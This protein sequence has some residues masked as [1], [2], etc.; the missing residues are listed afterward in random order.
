MWDFSLSKAIGA[1]IRTAPFVVLRMIVYFG[2]G[3]VYVMTVGIG[4]AVGYG[5]G[6]IGSNPDAPIGGAFWGGAIGFGLT[7][8]VLYFA[9]EYILYLVKA[10]HIAC[11]V[12]VLDDKPIPGGQGQLSYGAKFVETHFAEASVLFGVDQLIKAVLRSLFRIINF[13]TAFLP[14][15]G[16]Q[17]L[18]QAAEGVIRLSLTYVD[19]VL[20]AYLIRTRTTN[21]WDT[22]RDGLILYAQ[23]Y[24]HFL[25]NALW[26][27]MFL[28]LLTG[29]IFIVFL[30]PAAG[31]V[32][33]FPGNVTFWGFAIAFVF[34][35]AFKAAILDPI[36]VA[37]LMQV[38]F[39]TIEGQTTN[40]DW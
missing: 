1:V 33:L 14:I 7:S 10:A 21:P 37:G 28:W 11:L 25:K 39:K 36:A 31:L 22:A 26:L 13:V 9:R 40:A 12:E 23:N 20:L 29:A 15:P 38:F 5:F 4:A 35:W 34:A 30:A 3:I 27:A 8:A 2:V 18:I 16:L 6:H 32:A 24:T 17:G 19:E